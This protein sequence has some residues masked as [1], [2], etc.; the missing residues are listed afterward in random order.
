MSD[1]HFI[2]HSHAMFAVSPLSTNLPNPLPA[3]THRPT[4]HNP[5]GSDTTS[6]ALS[7]TLFYL[8]HNPTTLQTL[9]TS[10]RHT[11]PTLSSIRSGPLL[12]QSTYL[13][14][15][16]DEALRLSPP[17]GGLLP[18]EVLPGGLVV[19][20]RR[21]AAGTVV[22]VPVYA[23]HHREACFVEPWAFRPGRWL[24]G[25]GEGGKG[26]GDQTGKEG[27]GEGE[28][29]AS[30]VAGAREAFCPFSVGPRGCV[31][32]GMAYLELAVALAR[33]VWLFDLRLA[34]GGGGGEGEGSGVC[35]GEGN[36]EAEWGRHRRGE[37]QLFDAFV[38]M[39]DGPLVEFR[40][41]V[42]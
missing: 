39:K 2:F 21:F 18:R 6:T 27:E 26:G 19:D 37:Y 8:T 29:T 34:R 24:V 1:T 41:R 40:A 25:C 10:I 16:L 32:K 35:L 20:G 12:T 9:T 5:T 7:A 11:F 38:A 3:L 23:L 4:T 36:P 42:D 14:A 17:V 22:G 15:C 30:S 31:G 33:V 13:R 28:G